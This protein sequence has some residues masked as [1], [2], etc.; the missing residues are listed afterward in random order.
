MA[1]KKISEITEQAEGADLENARYIAAIPTTGGGFETKYVQGLASAG[2]YID[3]ASVGSYQSGSGSGSYGE[4]TFPNYNHDTQVVFGSFSGGGKLEEVEVGD[5]SSG[6]T[7]NDGPREGSKGSNV[8]MGPDASDPTKGNGT[9]RVTDYYSGTGSATVHFMRFTRASAGTEANG[10]M[11]RAYAHMAPIMNY[12]TTAETVEATSFN[13]TG[14]AVRTGTG[15]TMAGSA[16]WSGTYTFTYD[17]SITNPIAFVSD[18]SGGAT[19]MVDDAA[20]TVT[21]YT[22][23]WNTQGVSCLIL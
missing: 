8:R 9:V 7:G 19:Y 13:M 11:G 4:Y 16:N 14:S 3:S 6:Q 10:G 18:A 21:V 17:S 20:K 23:G 22:D 15:A 12:N 5:G 1:N 2:G